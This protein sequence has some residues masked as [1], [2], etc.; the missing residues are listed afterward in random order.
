MTTANEQLKHGFGLRESVLYV[1][2]KH[3][4][5]GIVILN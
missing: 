2:L 5:D 3:I 1:I 4:S